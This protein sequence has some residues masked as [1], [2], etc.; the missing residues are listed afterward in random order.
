MHVSSNGHQKALR[1]IGVMGRLFGW[2]VMFTASLAFAVPNAPPPPAQVVQDINQVIRMT[3]DAKNSLEPNA[4]N[5]FPLVWDAPRH[6]YVQWAGFSPNAG[7]GALALK[8][9]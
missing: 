2:A 9:L 8:T 7:A 4:P 1:V 5:S 6:D 3:S